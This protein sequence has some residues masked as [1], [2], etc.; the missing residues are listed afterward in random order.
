MQAPNAGGV[1]QFLPVQI[2]NCLKNKLQLLHAVLCDIFF[3]NNVDSPL[4]L[5]T[6]QDTFCVTSVLKMLL[7]RHQLTMSPPTRSAECILLT[8]K[9]MY[10]DHI[11]QTKQKTC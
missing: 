1:G 3:H 7:N 10:L 11:N 8:V 4:A 9:L 2:D 5:I 6:L